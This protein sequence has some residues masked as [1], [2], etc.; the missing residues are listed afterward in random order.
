MKPLIDLSKIYIKQSF[1]QNNKKKRTSFSLITSLCVIA[2]IV[3]FGLG[4]SFYSLANQLATIGQEKMILIVGSISASMFVLMFTLY[5]QQGFYYKTNDYDFLSSLPIKTSTVVLAKYISSYFLCL[6]YHTI[7]IL[8]AFIV[9]FIFTP[10]SF[11]AILYSI[12]SL[13]FSPLYLL[14]ISNV[15]T[16]II[17]LATARL[18]NKNIINSVFTMLFTLLI[19]VFVALGNNDSLTSFFSTG[20]IS[21][22]IKVLLPFLPPLFNAIVLNSF[23]QFL[24]FL[25]I[26]LLAFGLA[27]LLTSLTYKKINNFLFSSTSKKN[28][29]PMQFIPRKVTRS[30]V[31][32]D[33]MILINTPVYL[34][35]CIM[36][37]IML[38][39][40]AVLYAV[41][42]KNNGAT[43][44]EAEI[45]VGLF[46]LSGAMM[47]SI[48]PPSAVSVNV[49]GEKLLSLKSLPIKFIDIV[50]SKLGFNILAYLPF[51]L[52]AN[53]I[54]FALIP[55][56]FIIILL[57][58]LVQI[59]SLFL[60]AVVGLLLNLKFPLLK[61]SNVTQA[62]KQSMSMFVT[63][64]IMMIF[65]G[66]PIFLFIFFAESILISLQIEI[67]FLIILC[68]Y[69]L[70][71]I[72]FVWILLS[73][74]EKLYRKIQ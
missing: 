23:L 24:L 28:K 73:K 57:C 14:L 17:N 27:I 35:N 56:N 50:K 37:A 1:Q 19:I 6:F 62:V 2:L 16:I 58:L 39:F 30:L 34:V 33:F 20:E 61:W 29:G 60:S 53:I 55:T 40:F 70:A 48:V 32:K 63:M 12:I 22:W 5:Q 21:I 9:Y 72:A 67:F 41:L 13:F 7:F 8:P 3:I 4:F 54:F 59:T 47:I 68:F 66:L 38:V 51:I 25:A 36:G 69:I 26:N 10:I 18:K 49:E 44:S 15:L 64:A 31:K 65:C 42:A 11:T 52:I 43:A 45:F 71:L 74:G 46:A